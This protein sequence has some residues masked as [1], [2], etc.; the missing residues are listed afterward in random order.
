M[1][2]SKLH[3]LRKRFIKDQGLPI[4][5]IQDPYFDY[6]INELQI[7]YPGIKENYNEMLRIEKVT[8]NMLNYSERITSDIINYVKNSATYVEFNNSFMD[9]YVVPK[10][11]VMSKQLY[12]PE[13]D[14]LTFISIDIKKANFTSMKFFNNKMFGFNTYEDMIDNF[15]SYD[16]FKKSKYIR[17]VIFG[18]LNPKRQ[19]KI[20]KY[21]IYLTMMEI[22]KVCSCEVFSYSSDEIVLKVED[23]HTTDHM[24]NVLN[25]ALSTLSFYDSLRIESFTLNNFYKSHYVK[26]Y[27]DKIEFK[28]CPSTIFM[29][30][31]KKYYNQEILIEDKKFYYEKQMAT[32][33]N[34]I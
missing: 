32:F 25:D 2:T 7:L 14:K 13:N 34:E 3:S 22:N 12:L 5:V 26:E 20:Q 11:Y 1:E 15:T 17:Q 8:G 30:L 21:M 29:Q 28:Q 23:K 33:D 16:Y 24:L 18:N 6:Y 10:N 9:S 31:F 4:Q 27:Y 19:Q